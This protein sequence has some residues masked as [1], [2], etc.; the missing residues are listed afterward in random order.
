MPTLDINQLEAYINEKI[1]VA[2][3]TNVKEVAKTTM[4]EHVQIDVY[5]P[6]TPH[7]IDGVTPHYERTGKLLENVKATIEGN[8]LTLEDTR[9]ENGRD[10]TQI[11]ESGVGYDWG[12]KRNLDKE[13]GKRPFVEETYK[14]LANGKA[15]NALAEGL[16]IQGLN[17][18]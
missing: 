12:Y 16:R 17:I 3:E 6:Y 7:S 10:I 5:N 11:I 8:S 14:D 9:S 18:E 2:L 15:R 1:N 13:I 4:K